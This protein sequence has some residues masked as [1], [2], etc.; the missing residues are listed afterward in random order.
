MKVLVAEFILLVF[1]ACTFSDVQPAR[2]LQENSHPLKENAHP[3]QRNTYSHSRRIQ[4]KR[5]LPS[6]RDLSKS[7]LM[8]SL[9]V[10]RSPCRDP[11]TN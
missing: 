3:L 2:P 6:L 5:S 1:V 10:T 11:S 4:Y 9:R 7:K 8:N